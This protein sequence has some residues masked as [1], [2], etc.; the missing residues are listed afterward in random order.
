MRDHITAELRR[1]IE[2]A[3]RVE[4]PKELERKNFEGVQKS[5]GLVIDLMIKFFPD[6][7]VF[8]DEMGGV[9]TDYTDLLQTL[10]SDIADRKVDA[11]NASL[12][13]HFLERLYEEFFLAIP[14]PTQG[15]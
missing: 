12:V 14:K 1:I 4:I 6:N 8:G 5:C 3:I 11:R 2:R 9:E 10:K 7:L 13:F 15:K